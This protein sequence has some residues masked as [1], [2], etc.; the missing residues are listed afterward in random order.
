MEPVP[1]DFLDDLA[2]QERPKSKIVNAWRWAFICFLG[3][4]IVLFASSLRRLQE[5][6][7]WTG[8]GHFLARLVV[9]ML[10][11]ACMLQLL[12]SKRSGWILSVI[13]AV[14][15]L[16]G[17]LITVC[18]V[19]I[20]HLNQPGSTFFVLIDGTFGLINLG[21]LIVFLGEKGMAYWGVKATTRRWVLIIAL[22][23]AIPYFIFYSYPTYAL[24]KQ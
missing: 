2:P 3:T 9:A 14:D 7:A 1:V 23:A 10:S 20:W 8:P 19:G 11:I 24:F 15:F 18:Y 6:I 4:L 22:L 12:R 5:Q 16:C 21:L 17:D 13:L